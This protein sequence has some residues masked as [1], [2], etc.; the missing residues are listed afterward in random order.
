M[1]L[2]A[3]VNPETIKDGRGGIYTF[4]PTEPIVEFNAIFTRA[5]RTRGFHFH[6]EFIEYVLIMSGHGNYITR[7]DGV[8][9]CIK[10]GPGDAIVFMPGVSHTYYAIEDTAMV[11]M[12]T[13]KWKDCIEPLK[14]D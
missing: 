13:K 6:P 1:K 12:L 4:F 3:E 14:R 5:G 2:L 8:E 9:T 10:M 11:A 7:Q